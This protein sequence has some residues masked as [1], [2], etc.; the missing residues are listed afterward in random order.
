MIKQRLLAAL[1][2]TSLI[3]LPVATAFH[4]SEAYAQAEAKEVYTLTKAES[5]LVDFK[6]TIKRAMVANPETATL[7]VISGSELLVTGNAI[8]H[9]ELFINFRE[10]PNKT[11]RYLLKVEK[12]PQQQ[13]MIENTIRDLLQKLNPAGTVSFEV[14]SIWV[15]EK[16]NIQ[17]QID[18]V[19]NQ[20]DDGKSLTNSARQDQEVLQ[21]GESV[22]QSRISP[23]AGNLMVVLSGSVPND[24]QKKRIQS[25]ISTLG[26]SVLNMID[27]SGPQEVK[28]QVRVAEVVKGNPFKSG[29]LF[30]SGNTH[31]GIFPPGSDGGNYILNTLA[32]I[33]SLTAP[34]SGQAFQIGVNTSGNGMFGIL[35]V[36][37]GNNLARIL[38]R[39][40]LT[41]QSGETAE[42][43]VGGE[44]PIPVSQNDN[45]VTVRY[46]EFGVRLR[47]SP[48]ITESGE[49]KLTVAPEISNIDESAG[50]A[51]GGVIQPGFRSRRAKTTVTLAAGQSFVIGG[52]IQ[53][54]FENSISKVPFLGDIPILGALFRST[55]FNKDQTELAIVVTPTFVEPIAQGVD[56]QLPGENLVAPSYS[57]AFWFGKISATLPEGQKALPE[58]TNK[59]GLEKP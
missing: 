53:D 7:K 52:L 9:T 34:L 42:F 57:D 38:A 49:I 25:V 8:G 17:R 48:L 15:D 32:G 36:L 59:I 14:R 4:A 16:S 31:S 28:L 5:K 50:S 54:S 51:S 6:K 30:G 55:S 46:K 1:F 58:L 29:A 41:V 12:N 19:G 39:P 13:V 24:A 45:S 22:G 40:E 3:S 27:I 44:V 10:N 23:Q 20:I 56:I 18:E 11:Y 37:E 43:L 33:S 26:V 35:S 2:S 47:F 21:T